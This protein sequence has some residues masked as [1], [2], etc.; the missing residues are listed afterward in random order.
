MGHVHSSTQ[1][2]RVPGPGQADVSWTSLRNNLP[3][4]GESGVGMG[5]C[6]LCSALKC[7]RQAWETPKYILESP[8]VFTERRQPLPQNTPYNPSHPREPDAA[9]VS[10][11]PPQFGPRGDVLWSH[12]PLPGPRLTRRRR[13]VRL[14]SRR[15]KLKA[16][17]KGSAPSSASCSLLER[18]CGRHD[19]AS[20]SQVLQDSLAPDWD[21]PEGDREP[22]G[23]PRQ[24][25]HCAL[26]PT[27]VSQNA[28]MGT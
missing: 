3:A 25:R 5:W 24:I 21:P 9:S 12:P 14:E 26:N 20:L 1:P 4:R 16:D 6:I 2:A 13:A 19:R 17:S 10:S 11:A 28:V 15:W 18:E 7:S 8:G 22:V 23:Q 27:E